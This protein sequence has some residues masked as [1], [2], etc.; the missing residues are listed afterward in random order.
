MMIICPFLYCIFNVLNISSTWITLKMINQYQKYL[1]ISI[2]LIPL[3]VNL[4]GCAPV[5]PAVP[6]NYA[7]QD[8]DI[9]EK[10]N[11]VARSID[12]SL[13]TLAAAQ[14]V[15]TLNAINTAPLVTAKGG[16][17]CKANLDWSGPIEPLLKEVA[18]LTHYKVK[19]LGNAPAIPIIV[20]ITADG[21]VMADILK[22][23]GLQAGKRANLV[24]Y[25][26]SKIIELR[27][28]TI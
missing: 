6:A 9:N 15:E 24:V 14:D 19:V 20:S 13:R 28:V 5:K 7:S 12:Q 17:G 26:S 2:V 18:R 4:T 25:P 1:V 10:L 21:R 8:I 27:Y 16:M 22:D 3:L 23:A 11:C